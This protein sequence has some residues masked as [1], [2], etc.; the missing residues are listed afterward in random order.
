[1]ISKDISILLLLYKTPKEKIQNLKNYKDFNI[2]IL[3]QSY[4][5]NTKKKLIK[6]LPNIKY[7]GLSNNN[8]GFAGGINFLVKKIKTK[9]FLCTQIDILIKKKSIIELKKVFINK[10]DCA[11]STPNFYNQNN[12]K[13]RFSLVNKFIGAVFLA[14]KKK[15]NQIGK[16][17]EDFFFYWEDED[18]SKRIENNKKFNIYKC[19]NSFAK[20]SSGSSTI[21]TDKI[22][23][24]RY[25]N[26]KFGEYLF[27]YNHN[28]LKKIK[29]IREPFS[30]I[31]LLI[32]NI[33]FFNR[34]KF[35][36]N[37]YYLIGIF[38]FF[39]FIIQKKLA[40]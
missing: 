35:D 6:L 25:T 3:D 34:V 14:D 23:Y 33:I 21:I 9:F 18:L 2:Y 24:I 37:L 22:N 31:L 16:F 17:N 20:H 29:V 39:R 13:K 15:F 32:L 36:T 27:Q 10:K 1:M 30:R 26:F 8:K 5:H 28:Q 19:N 4:D 12:T 40:L 7:Y 38:R 11:I